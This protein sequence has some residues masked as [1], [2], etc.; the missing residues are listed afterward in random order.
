MGY[1]FQI[2]ASE[3]Y[4]EKYMSF[5]LEHYSELNLPYPFPITL[6]YIASPVLMKEEAMLAFNDQDELVAALGYIYGTGENLYK[7]SHIIQIQT[8]FLVDEQRRTRLFFEGLQ[9]LTQHLAELDKEVT[10]IRYWVP[11]Q[12]ELRQLFDKLAQRTSSNPTPY[13]LIDEYVAPLSHWLQYVRLLS[14]EIKRG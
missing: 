1:Y 14:H 11:A 9:F 13:G 3:I 7:D 4:Q 5:L 12:N 8:V 6:S 2:C 10:E